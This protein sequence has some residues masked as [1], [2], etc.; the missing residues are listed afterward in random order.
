[1]F[2]QEALEPNEGRIQWKQ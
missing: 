1:V 2:Y